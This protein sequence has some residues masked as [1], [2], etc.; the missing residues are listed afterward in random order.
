MIQGFK[1]CLKSNFV[2]NGRLGF[3][4]TIT[5]TGKVRERFGT[6]TGKVR[7]RHGIGFLGVFKILFAKSIVF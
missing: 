1:R 5:G 3:A 7:R 2:E 6:G 4:A